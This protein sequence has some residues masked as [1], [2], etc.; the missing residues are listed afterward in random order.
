MFREITT[1]WTFRNAYIFFKR[2]KIALS[3]DVAQ[4]SFDLDLSIKMRLGK[5]PIGIRKI[6]I[7]GTLVF[8]LAPL[9]KVS[10]R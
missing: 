1:K 2:F 8:L 7:R 9:L 10:L 6:T 3:R 4:A 5:L